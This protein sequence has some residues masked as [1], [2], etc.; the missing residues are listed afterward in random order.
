MWTSRGIHD[1]L[2]TAYQRFAELLA[3]DP[4]IGPDDSMPNDCLH[5]FKNLWRDQGVQL[6]IRKGN[7]Y[8]LHDNLT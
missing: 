6:A 1:V 2:L 3:A 8:A 7:E 5:A 4:E